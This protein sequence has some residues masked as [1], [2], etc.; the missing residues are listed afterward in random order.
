[1]KKHK[2]LWGTI[3]LLIVPLSLLSVG[4]WWALSENAS[5]L[6]PT[7]PAAWTTITLG[8]SARKA[9]DF[10]TD[11]DLDVSPRDPANPNDDT[12]YITATRWEGGNFILFLYV[13]Q[14]GGATWTKYRIK[15]C[16]GFE[17]YQARVGVAGFQNAD[18]VSVGWQD[19]SPGNYDILV[20]TF[21]V[22]QATVGALPAGPSCP[23]GTPLTPDPVARPRDAYPAAA[24]APR[25]IP[26]TPEMVNVSKSST[27]SGNHDY[28]GREWTGSWD[29]S[30]SASCLTNNFPLVWAVW[31]EDY[32]EVRYSRSTNGVNW[33]D[34][35]ALPFESGLTRFPSAYSG[36]DGALYAGTTTASGNPDVFLTVST[37][38]GQT[39]GPVAN[40]SSN[41][42]FSDAPQVAVTG[43]G[44]IHTVY[45]DTTVAA[46][47]SADNFYTQCTRTGN[48]LTCQ[49][50]TRAVADGAFPHIA[51]DGKS[52]LMSYRA[53]P[54]GKNRGL[55]IS[56]SPDSKPTW[57]AAYELTDPAGAI[58]SAASPTFTVPWGVHFLF[59]KGALANQYGYV[60]WI[61]VGPNFVRVQFSKG[62][63]PGIGC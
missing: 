52:L 28:G 60:G 33:A 32:A 55:G 12:I 10:W 29:L 63:R 50:A 3:L 25:V 6:Q 11:V 8:D 35:A 56:C 26:L 45:D 58:L 20:Q 16:Q 1:M 37:D 18:I 61:Q 42:G 31:A 21:C 9:G 41:P 17:C 36:P 34:P 15:E 62:V 57:G 7:G 38:C 4:V 46:A 51:T 43:D 40:L 53:I 5:G 2:T 14:D 59:I 44:K 22:A 49:P 19:L 27:N 47:N 54:G 23:S 13:S 24:T 39:W 30:V 48:Q